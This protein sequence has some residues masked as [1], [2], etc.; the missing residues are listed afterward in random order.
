MAEFNY[1]QLKKL[2]KRPVAFYAIFAKIA[3][4]ALAGLMLS[5]MWWL[6]NA[7]QVERNDGWFKKTQQELTEETG[8]TRWEQETAREQ[9]IACGLLT[10]KIAGLPAKTYYKLNMEKVLEAINDY[11]KNGSIPATSEAVKE[12]HK[13]KLHPKSTTANKIVVGQQASLLSDNEQDSDTTTSK[14][15]VG[16]QTRQRYDNKQ[17]SDTTANKIVV[18]QQAFKKD[19]DLKRD[20]R[21]IEEEIR[22]EVVS[23]SLNDKQAFNQSSVLVFPPEAKETP[24]TQIET[25]PEKPLTNQ[26]KLL[27]S[28]VT[29]LRLDMRVYSGG[30]GRLAKETNLFYKAEITPEQIEKFAKWWYLNDFRGKQDQAPTIDQVSKSLATALAWIDPDTIEIAQ[31]STAIAVVRPEPQEK[32]QYKPFNRADDTQSNVKSVF[33][34]VRQGQALKQIQEGEKNE[35]RIN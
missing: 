35:R 18:G 2:L 24:V 10:Q 6:A 11:L 13:R 31:P 12:R 33:N 16:Q 27:E 8:L 26:Q 25:K 15:V 23:R 20:I 22:E 28:F 3:G 34:K 21:E 9:L 29:L 19:L 30:Y 5:Q 1:E 4:G 17:D 32:Q 14:F 7:D